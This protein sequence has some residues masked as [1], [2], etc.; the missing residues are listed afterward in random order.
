[1]RIAYSTV[2]SGPPL[3]VPPAGTS[4]LEVAWEFPPNRA[5][6]EALA[7]RFTYITYDR[8][9]CGLSDHDRTDFS[10]AAELAC[11]EAVIDR[12][13]LEQCRRL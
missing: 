2:G 10:L 1:V 9:G 8:R 7:Q 6:V 12:L 5:F 13:G 11:C 4:H 3:V